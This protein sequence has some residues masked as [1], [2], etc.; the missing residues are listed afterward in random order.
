M[1]RVNSS[2]VMPCLSSSANESPPAGMFL[3]LRSMRVLSTTA[4]G[5]MIVPPPPVIWYL[6][7]WASSAVVTAPASCDE[8]PVYSGA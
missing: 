1:L 8:R 3:A 6:T 7:C 4:R 2:V 5:T